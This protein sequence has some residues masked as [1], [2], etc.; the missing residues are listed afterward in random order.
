MRKN[1]YVF[2]KFILL[3]S[4]YIFYS[5]WNPPFVILLWISTVLD[6]TAAKR[7][8]A[9]SKKK[10]KISWLLFSLSVN[11]GLLIFFKYG[12]FI[13]ENINF[14][15]PQLYN[16][17]SYSIILPVGISFYTFQTLS[18][19]LDIY[20][21]NAKP[22]KSF[23]DYALYVT[24][25]PQLVAG[26]IVRSDEFLEQC[27]IEKPFDWSNL[28]KGIF[29]LITG[30]FLKI[31]VADYLLAPVVEIVFGTNGKVDIVSSWIGTLAFSSQILCDFDVAGDALQ[32]PRPGRCTNP[33]SPT[34]AKIN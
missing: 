24:F 33:T 27:E 19:T 25:F 9:S 26:P 15:S 13:L 2:R 21:G 11:L 3:I 8:Y 30:L 7:I 14:I 22:S 5:A 4:S 20:R 18:Y 17:Q 1:L 23:L 28:G 34:M 29:W 6:W 32:L 16:F 12:N 10:Y 31:V